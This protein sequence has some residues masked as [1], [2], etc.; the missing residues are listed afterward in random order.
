ME[1]LNAIRI[2]LEKLAEILCAPADQKLYLCFEA[3]DEDTDWKCLSKKTDRDGWVFECLP[4]LDMKPVCILHT[5]KLTPADIYTDVKNAVHLLS[6]N[7]DQK[8]IYLREERT[9]NFQD[10]KKLMEVYHPDVRGFVSEKEDALITRTLHLDQRDI[11]DLRNLRDFVVLFIGGRN[12]K[13]QE[14]E[15]IDRMSAITH[16]IDLKIWSLGGEV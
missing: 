7:P 16:V 14:M 8:E 10:V 1:H 3:P 11:L 9:T 5:G 12:K 2:T 13:E 15:N 6:L 4:R